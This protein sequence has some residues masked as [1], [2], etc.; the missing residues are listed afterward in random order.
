[1]CSEATRTKYTRL[2]RAAGSSVRQRLG[3]TVLMLFICAASVFALSDDAGTQ[4]TSRWFTPQNIL[5]VGV[6]VYHLGML[7]SQFN[8]VQKRLERFENNATDLYA[9]KEETFRRLESLERRRIPR[10]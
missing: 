3:L 2:Y 1:M 8:E 9:P 6:L 5:T 7:R 10:D 4:D